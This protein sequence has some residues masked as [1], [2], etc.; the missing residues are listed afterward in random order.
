M[1]HRLLS[2]HTTVDDGLFAGD[3]NALLVS[4]ASSPCL[5]GYCKPCP[6]WVIVG[7]RSGRSSPIME[8]V[9]TTNLGPPEEKG[10]ST[11]DLTYRSC[12]T[13]AG[14]GITSEFPSFPHRTTS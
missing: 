5:A 3:N 11:L 2:S 14:R 1:R 10:G 8:V 4:A 9:K 12:H 7:N 6:L 13:R